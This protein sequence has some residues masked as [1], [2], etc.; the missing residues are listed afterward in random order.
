[1]LMDTYVI[2]TALVEFNGKFLIAKRA[3]TKKFSP[4]HWEFIS[5]FIEEKESA[6]ETIVR[7]LDEETKFKG[8]IIKKADPFFFVDEEARWVV[9]PFLIKVENGKEVINK[10][11][12]SEAKWIHIE[13]VETYKDLMPFSKMRQLLL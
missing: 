3:S 12:H 1:M 11:D 7:E 9:I 10:K 4:N 2:T 5:G 8:K 13:E 6:E